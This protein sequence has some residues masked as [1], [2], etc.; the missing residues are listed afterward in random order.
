MKIKIH[1]DEFDIQS[2][3]FIFVKVKYMQNTNHPKKEIAIT[4]HLATLLDWRSQWN[5]TG[6][7]L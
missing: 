7:N 3:I 2:D 5:F 4:S 6:E 1:M